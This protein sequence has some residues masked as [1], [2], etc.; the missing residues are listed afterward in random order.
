[1]RLEAEFAAFFND[2]NNYIFLGQEINSFL[3]QLKSD[4]LV[5]QPHHNPGK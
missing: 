1:M 4:S 2:G 3:Q 5:G